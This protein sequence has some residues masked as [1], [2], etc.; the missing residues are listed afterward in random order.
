MLYR[1]RLLAAISAY[2]P[3]ARESLL[4]LRRE[5]YG[6]SALMATPE[7]V[8]WL[9]E[10]SEGRAQLWVYRRS[11]RVRGQQGAIPVEL[12]IHG[13][14]VRAIWTI[15]LAVS[16]PLQGWGIG[17]AL[18][19]VAAKA[20]PVRLGAE[21]TEAARRNYLQSGWIDLGDLPLWVRP[22]DASALLDGRIR[23]P[24]GSVVAPALDACLRALELLDRATARARRVSLEEVERFDD[25]ADAVWEA[26]VASYSVICKRDSKHLNWRFVE[27]VGSERSTLV[28]LM[29]DRRPVGWAVLRRGMRHGRRCGEIVDF[30]CPRRWTHALLGACVA[31]FREQRDVAAVYC[32]HAGPSA[33]LRAQGFVRRTSGWPLMVHAGS[34]T[35]EQTALL[36]DPRAWFVT[37]GDANLDRPRE[38]TLDAET[39]SVRASHS[40]EPMTC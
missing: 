18:D 15:E 37:A 26:S 3:D 33:A 24:F 39:D 38:G 40:N 13:Q 20:A 36:R 12:V 16:P 31:F 25:R 21:V 28:H 34:L 1:D 4:E 27:R 5:V 14:P 6:A 7:Y 35:P 19:L 2:T 10:S 22:L 30:L 9:Y 23:S 11:G 8:R 17:H 32:L 29:A